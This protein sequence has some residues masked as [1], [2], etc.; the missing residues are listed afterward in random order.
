MARGVQ[1]SSAL[2][3]KF[4]KKNVEFTSKT[5][6]SVNFEQEAVNELF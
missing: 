2:N 1:G 6:F 5:T 3:F 4:H